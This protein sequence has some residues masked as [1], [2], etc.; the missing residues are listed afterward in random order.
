VCESW[1]AGDRRKLGSRFVASRTGEQATSRS[2][3][4]EVLN[5][6]TAAETILVDVAC[7]ESGPR[8]RSNA[9]SCLAPKYRFIE[10]FNALRQSGV[11]N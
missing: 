10:T 4:Q 9:H 11:P 1:A 5:R 7:G 6:R 2:P 8:G 3:Q